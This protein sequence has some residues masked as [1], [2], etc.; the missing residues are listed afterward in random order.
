MGRRKKLVIFIVLGIVM[1]GTLVFANTEIPEKGKSKRKVKVEDRDYKDKTSKPERGK[2]GEIG[3][4]KQVTKYTYVTVRP[5]VATSEYERL[6]SWSPDGQEIVFI[7]GADSYSG[8]SSCYKINQD[9]TGLTLLGEGDPDT[10]TACYRVPRFS[11]DGLKILYHFYDGE[12]GAIWMMDPD[13]SNKE[14]VSPYDDYYCRGRGGGVWSPDGER[15]YYMHDE[16]DYIY[17]ITIGTQTE[18]DL[19]SQFTYSQCTKKEWPKVSPDGEWILFKNEDWEPAIISH[20]GVYIVI[21]SIHADDCRYYDWSPDGGKIVYSTCAYGDMDLWIANWDGTGQAPLIEDPDTCFVEPDWSPD[22]KWILYTKKG[23]DC[24]NVYVISIDG[25]YK[26]RLTDHDSTTNYWYSTPEWSPLGDKIVYGWHNGTDMDIYIIDLDAGDNDF[27]G[28]LNWEEEAAYKT[29]PDD[30]DTDGGDENDGSEIAN[31]RDP[32]D[33]GDDLGAAPPYTDG[34]DPAPGET[35]VSPETDIVVHVK[36]DGAGVDESSIVMTVEGVAV[37]PSITGAPHD[38]T[39][40]YVPPAPFDSGEVINVT[41][42][43][44][45]LASSPNAM[46]QDAYFFTIEVT[47][48]EETEAL[49]TEFKLLQNTPNPMHDRTEIRFHVPFTIHVTLRIFDTSGRSIRTLIN[50]SKEPG[51]Y[52]VNWDRRDA[53]NKVVP[54]GIYLYE[55]SAGD[56]KCVKKMVVQ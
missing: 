14:R 34:H 17:F 45:D 9:G 38:F 3:I 25:L 31:G 2:L 51:Y 36:D 48:V 55:L 27:D 35:E 56:Y 18:V 43:A 50:E 42:D 15:V 22:G 29:N 19:I 46:P 40:T 28:L 26:A 8:Y 53:S 7:Q 54:S 23:D 24:N 21:D 37:T 47:G 10:Y 32:L 1:A 4:K 5:L 20:S 33:P 30:R 13:G 16:E 12:T 39:L 11:P 6:P 49:P 52:S 44:V 41:I